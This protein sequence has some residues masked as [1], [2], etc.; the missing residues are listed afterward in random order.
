LCFS[1][2]FWYA[3][4][5]KNILV[6]LIGIGTFY[7]Q[8]IIGY[9]NI[10][11]GAPLGPVNACMVCAQILIC[12]YNLTAW[13]LIFHPDFKAMSISREGARPTPGF[14]T[15]QFVQGHAGGE[16]KCIFCHHHYSK[17][18]GCWTPGWQPLQWHNFC[19]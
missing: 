7:S 3:T 19:R 10:H 11:I 4:N 6:F 13:S 5:Y 18:S 2:L 12:T 15:R 14:D 8:Y 1:F 17:I 9:Q 16:Y